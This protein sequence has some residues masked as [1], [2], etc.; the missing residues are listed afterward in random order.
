MGT[1]EKGERMKPK[2][3]GYDSKKVQGELV[4]KVCTNF[5]R[6][7]EDF[8]EERHLALRGHRTGDAKREEIMMGDP[9]INQTA[10]WFGITPMKVRKLLITG[11]CYDTKMYRD[12]KRLREKR[13][14]VEQIGEKLKKR[15]ESIRSYLPYERVIYNLEER[16]VNADRLQ[17]FKKKWGSYK[18]KGVQKE[19][20]IEA[21]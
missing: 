18:K 10:E 5:G 1:N 20:V 8:E 17:R 21:K 6:V 14:S 13:M 16:S 7:Y 11:G 15:P 4:E 9:T 3:P 2:K 19:G 12:V